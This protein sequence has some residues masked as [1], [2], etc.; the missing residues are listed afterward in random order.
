MTA[1]A[2]ALVGIAG[3]IVGWFVAGSQRV[4][5]TLTQER[6]AAY[7]KVVRAASA[8]AEMPNGDRAELRSAVLEANFVA[9]DRLA[10]SNR[11]SGLLRD[12]GSDAWK[13]RLDDFTALARLETQNNSSLRRWWNR[14]RY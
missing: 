14:R 9:S 4:T 7:L 11:I 12:P 6:R 3:L 2:T 10:N 13:A 5:E 1:A 8:L